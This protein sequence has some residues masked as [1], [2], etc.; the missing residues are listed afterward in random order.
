MALHCVMHLE[1]LKKKPEVLPL[2]MSFVCAPLLYF[3]SFLKWSHAR[4]AEASGGTAK[5]NRSIVSLLKVQVLSRNT[6]VKKDLKQ[7]QKFL[8]PYDAQHKLRI[9]FHLLPG[10][11]WVFTETSFL[12]LFLMKVN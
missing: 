3:S 4:S 7:T 1:T 6:E 2:L 5:E 10:C 9:Y 8:A 12:L 11:L